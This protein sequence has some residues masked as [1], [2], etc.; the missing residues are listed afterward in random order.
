MNE[1]HVK[2]MCDKCKLQYLGGC[3]QDKPDDTSLLLI[4]TQV[5]VHKDHIGNV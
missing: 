2:T 1:E 3:V 5:C 4:N